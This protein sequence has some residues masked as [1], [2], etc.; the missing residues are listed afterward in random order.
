M[1]RKLFQAIRNWAGREQR[2]RELE[3]ELGSFAALRADEKVAAGTAPATARREALMEIGGMEQ[4]KEQVREVRS[5]ASLEQLWQDLR[6]GFRMLRR[7]PA[8]TAVAVV[9]LA[10]GIGATT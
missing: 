10:L 5:G 4:I 3:A 6:F 1:G 7:A 8:F 9:T 2:E